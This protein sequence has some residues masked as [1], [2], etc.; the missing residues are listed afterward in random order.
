MKSE[1]MVSME[2]II[3]EIVSKPMAT[4][5][6]TST[7]KFENTSNNLGFKT[8]LILKPVIING[9]TIKNQSHIKI[10]NNI[11][12]IMQKPKASL[13]VVTKPPTCET[14]IVKPEPS[15]LKICQPGIKNTPFSFDHDYIED[16]MNESAGVSKVSILWVKFIS[17]T[18]YQRRADFY[19]FDLSL[20]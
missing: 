8:P 9:S 12:T 14:K 10:G 15:A 20:R 17:I 1:P 16:D 11:F 18:L 6:T 19:L 7:A 13:S 3:N 5:T 2:M 4:V